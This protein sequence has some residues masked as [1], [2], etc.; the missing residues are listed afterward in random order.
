M[1]GMFEMTGRSGKT[2]M[3]LKGL[4]AGCLECPCN[5]QMHF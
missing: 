4:A 3:P 5:T 2:G 1:T